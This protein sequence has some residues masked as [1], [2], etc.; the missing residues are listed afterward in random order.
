MGHWECGGALGDTGVGGRAL[1]GTGVTGG[2][3]V[4]GWG[5]WGGSGAQREVHCRN[6]VGVTEEVPA[7]PAVSLRPPRCPRYPPQAADPLVP[8]L[9]SVTEEGKKAQRAGRP[10]CSA[11]FRRRPDPSPGGP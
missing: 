1:G 6:S 11:V 9:P 5:L 7:V 3:P 4:T 8:L 2:Y 10:P